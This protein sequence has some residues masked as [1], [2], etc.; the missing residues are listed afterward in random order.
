MDQLA[1]EI[2][3]FE[4]TEKSFKELLNR[5]NSKK[6]ALENSKKQHTSFE[7]QKEN[8]MKII[9]ENQVKIKILQP[10]FDDLENAK[11]KVL[12]LES[13]EKIKAF[14][15][16]L[17]VVDEKIKNA[18]ALHVEVEKKEQELKTEL[19]AI[20]KEQ[21]AV[22]T[23]RMDA[24]LLVEIGNWY[25]IKE[26][27]SVKL[28]DIIQKSAQVQNE[29]VKQKELFSKSNLP[30]ENWKEVV[31][32]KK[33]VLLLQKK[34]LQAV[35][36][37]LMV[38]KE[39][40]HFA[41][42][43]HEGE[44]CPLCGALEHPNV[45]QAED[46][47]G[48][49]QSN[50]S[51]LSTIEVQETELANRTLLAEKFELS[52]SHLKN[53]LEVLNSEK[54]ATE[55][56]IQTHVSKFIW[57]DFNAADITIF[58][59]KKKEQIEVE[60]RIK[61]IEEKEKTVRLQKDKQ[62][63]ALKL[64]LS[65]RGILVAEQASKLGAIT[66][67]LTQLKKLQFS[68]YD[69]I[70][71]ASIQAERVAL[72][73][74][75]S[76]IATEYD[77]LSKE[78]I[79]KEQELSGID[80]SLVSIKEQLDLNENEVQKNQ[81]EITEQLKEHQ[82]NSVDEVQIILSKS[83]DIVAE[84]A[85]TTQFVI[86]LKV[87]ENAVAEAQ[88]G[89]G[90]RIFDIEIFK[91]K[92]LLLAST[93]EKTDAQLGKVTSL[94]TNLNRILEEFKQKEELQNEFN[95][96]QTRYANLNTLS[97]MFSGS[98]FVNYV[99]SIYLQNLADS[100]NIRFHRMT[101]NQLSLTINASNEFEVIDYLNNGARRS[102]KTLSG[103]Q[104]F[105]ASLCLALALAESVQSLNKN[106]K[107]FFFIDEGFGTQDTESIAIVFETLQSLYKENRIVGIISH[108]AELQERIPRSINVVKDEEKGSFVTESWN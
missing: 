75:N 65:N 79:K 31:A 39:L 96:V 99:S 59:S 32:S 33:E 25:N 7:D 76:R 70:P 88:K 78:K 38:S 53:Q 26:N 45:M 9:E 55:I 86:D 100:A 66:N 92:Q 47:S 46:V 69:A 106:D 50:K 52:F 72:H 19:E 12:D 29:I 83:W 30:F 84:K 4:K 54:S 58:D 42:N 27:Q 18:D 28:A 64:L 15:T 67:E 102:V 90:N 71:L 87:A 51:A 82:F 1:S 103:G 8:V 85:K 34:E 20:Q 17:I 80:G 16:D 23:K 107:N 43:L 6:I 60:N 89:M 77:F 35:Q 41:D 22:K 44:D 57:T 5:F 98:G 48:Q 74:E 108:V 56:A 101:K 2:A 49:L 91:A 13:I 14:K 40:A 61:A 21:V 63:N 97:N 104:G 37:K 11:T 62:D 94:Q 73:Q 95:T 36:T 105:Q 93:K 10:L 24:N 81:E 3:S 68:D